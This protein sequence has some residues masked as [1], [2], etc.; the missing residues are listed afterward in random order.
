MIIVQTLYIEIMAESKLKS[1]NVNFQVLD[2]LGQVLFSGN[3]Y[4]LTYQKS[5]EVS[6]K[7]IFSVNFVFTMPLLSSGSYVFRIA[8]SIIDET[9]KSSNLHT[10]P[11]ALAIHSVTRGTRHG[12]IGVPMH[13]IKLKCVS[14][15]SDHN[16]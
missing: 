1:P 6:P 5:F 16:E 10:N 13:A 9:G 8:T 15:N 11:H 14:M 3:S 12:L 7:E 2:R 4:L